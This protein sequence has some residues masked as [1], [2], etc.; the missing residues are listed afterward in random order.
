M[1]KLV[2]PRKAECIAQR[3]KARKRQDGALDWQ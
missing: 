2:S 1:M 3:H